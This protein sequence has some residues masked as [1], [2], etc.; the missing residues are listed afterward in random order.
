MKAIEINI[1]DKNRFEAVA[2][3]LDN[4][5]IENDIVALRKRVGLT[6]KLIP[7]YNF[8]N[9]FKLQIDYKLSK[10][11]MDYYNNLIERLELLKNQGCSLKE[12]NK[13]E[14]E[15]NNWQDPKYNFLRDIKNILIKFRK[16]LEF[17]NALVK[18]VICGEVQEADFT[19]KITRKDVRNIARDREWYW[20]NR[21]L[22][23]KKRKGYG[24]IANDKNQ[25]LRTV[26]SAVKSYIKRLK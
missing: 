23:G 14:E 10:T 12:I 15:I 20:Q 5:Q 16:N 11:D 26:E 19:L 17:K 6:T 8:Q 3:F 25:S 24:K 4:P 13:L 2:T 18:A 1:K 22:K 7:Y 9:F 21:R